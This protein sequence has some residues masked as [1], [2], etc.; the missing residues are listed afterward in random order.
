MQADAPT[1]RLDDPVTTALLAMAAG[2]WSWCA[3]LNSEGIVLG[4]LRRTDA[5]TAPTRAVAVDVM[6]EGPSTYRPDVPLEELVE[7]MKSGSFELAIVSD[8]D[9]RWR[10]LVSRQDAE[11]KLDEWRRR[12]LAG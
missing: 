4:R 12:Q 2:G 5:E 6:E 9:G 11:A 3:V 10:G 1:C 8:P 7:A